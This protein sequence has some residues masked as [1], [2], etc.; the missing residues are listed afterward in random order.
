MCTQRHIIFSHCK[1]T[2]V[3]IIKCLAQEFVE[4]QANKYNKK[5]PLIYKYRVNFMI[6][7]DLWTGCCKGKA[8][9]LCFAERQGIRAQR[10]EEGMAEPGDF[11]TLLRLP[12]TS[13]GR[14]NWDV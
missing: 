4:E 14:I 13:K 7:R 1:C 2:P 10:Q 11:G 3:L 5:P 8:E 6:T 9:G 12:S